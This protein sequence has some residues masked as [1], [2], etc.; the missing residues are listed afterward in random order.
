MAGKPP[1]Q[2][3]T[4]G[5]DVPPNTDDGDADEAGGLSLDDAAQTSSQPL[6]NSDQ[7]PTPRELQ[8]MQEIAHLRAQVAA[9]GA[10]SAAVV[11]EPTTPKGRE[12]IAT[13]KHRHLTARELTAMVDRGECAEPETMVLCKDGY[14]V[15]RKDREKGR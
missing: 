11:Y 8:L 9:G 5:E 15:P 2:V 1:R 10:P 7:A 13:S 4:P 3:L 14:Y 12:A 6:N